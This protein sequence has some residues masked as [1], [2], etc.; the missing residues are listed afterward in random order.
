MSVTLDAIHAG[1]LVSLEPEGQRSGIVKQRR[2]GP[3]RVERLGLVGDE[4]AD[5]RVHGGPEKAVHHY[6]ADHYPQLARSFATA[7]TPFAP[8]SLGENLSSLG[9]TEVNVHI[10]DVYRAGTVVLQVSQPRSPCWKI[11]HRFGNERLS[12]FI[13][14]QRIT[15]WYY[16][17]LEAGVLEAGDRLELLDRQAAAWSIDQFWQIQ[18]AHRPDLAALAGLMAN[19]GLAPEWQQRLAHRH[20]WLVRQQTPAAGALRASA[21]SRSA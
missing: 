21:P 15:G 16:R 4:Q 8:G 7:T 17:V 11:N 13:A 2:D 12:R 1:G 18:M 19:P 3:V 14:N 10:G 6:A 20:A 9:L 5:T